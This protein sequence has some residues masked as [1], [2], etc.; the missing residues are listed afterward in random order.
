M[1]E[2]VELSLRQK[3]QLVIEPHEQLGLRPRTLDQ[4]CDVT[5]LTIACD[6]DIHLSSAL[7]RRCAASDPAP[8]WKT[9]KDR[10]V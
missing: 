5:A 3:G 9:E 6:T 4:H 8:C 2:G 7:S 1:D 10:N